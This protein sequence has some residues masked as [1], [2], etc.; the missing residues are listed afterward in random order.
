L[1]LMCLTC[2]ANF[3]GRIEIFEGQAVNFVDKMANTFQQV[4]LAWT[5]RAV[6]VRVQ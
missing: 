1:A 3:P 5:K 2:G 4:T 6:H